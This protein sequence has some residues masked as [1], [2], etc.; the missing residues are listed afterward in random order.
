MLFVCCFRTHSTLF[1]QLIL[2]REFTSDDNSASSRPRTIIRSIAVRLSFAFVF[3]GSKIS[4]TS[5]TGYCRWCAF[6]NDYSAQIFVWISSNKWNIR[7][8]AAWY[9]NANG[10]AWPISGRTP[11]RRMCMDTDVP[12]CGCANEFVI[13]RVAW[14]V[15]RIPDTQM[16]FRPCVFVCDSSGPIFEWMPSGKIGI[17]M[18]FH[19]YAT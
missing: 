15:W 2:C 3:K 17:R 6:S 7:T 9:A 4:P 19:W 12:W 10:F 16:A 8:V 13:R 11:F 18:V 1:A 5:H 14:T